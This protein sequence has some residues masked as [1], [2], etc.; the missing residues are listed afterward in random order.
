MRVTIKRL[1]DG[2]EETLG[3]SLNNMPDDLW[4]NIMPIIR[5][6]GEGSYRIYA[7]GEPLAYI[8][9]GFVEDESEF[10]A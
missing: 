6:Y 10:P 4:G 2:N 1:S 9:I 8:S 7:D 5:H 3:F